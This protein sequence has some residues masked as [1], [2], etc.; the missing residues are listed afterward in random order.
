MVF[1]L[2]LLPQS[3]AAEVWSDDFDD[4]TINGWT[5]TDGEWTAADQALESVT[6]YDWRTVSTIWH[7]S[8]TTTGTWSFDYKVYGTSDYVYTTI[9]FMVNGTDP[10]IDY[11]GYGIRIRATSVCLGKQ[12][13]QRW[14]FVAFAEGVAEFDDLCGTWTHF[15]IT[16]DSAGTFNVYINATSLTDEP[17]ITMVNTEYDYS[18]RFAIYHAG[19]IDACI[20]NLVVND[21]IDFTYTPPTTPT[22]PTETTPTTSD[23]PPPQSMDATLLIAGA[24]AVVVIVVAVVFLKKR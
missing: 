6:D 12:F 17:A 14:N 16:R 9:L 1:V 23:S 21:A 3:A 13:G 19:Q 18:E 22:S 2:S 8:N 10:P 7:E 20:D 11:Y 24:G 4:Y 15:D 5:V